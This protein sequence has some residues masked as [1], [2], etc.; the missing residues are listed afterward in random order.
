M[1]NLVGSIQAITS[2][3]QKPYSYLYSR[4]TT[5]ADSNKGATSVRKL[6]ALEMGETNRINVFKGMLDKF[7]G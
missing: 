7:D 5:V 4:E 2:L 3:K 6:I 1:C